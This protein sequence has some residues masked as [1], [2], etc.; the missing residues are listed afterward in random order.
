MFSSTSLLVTIALALSVAANPILFNQRRAGT[1]ITL[2]SAKR[3][4]ATGTFNLVVRDQARAKNLKAKG[5]NP[6]LA[7]KNAGVVGSIP[8]TNQAVDYTVDV[9]VGNPPTTYTLLVDTGSSNTWVGSSKPYIQTSTSIQTN[10]QVAVTYGIGDMEGTEFNDKLSLDA[11]LNVFG[12]SLGVAT[13]STGFDD[14]DGILGLGPND[15]TVGT[16]K[17]DTKSTIPTVTDNLF[18]QAV[19]AANQVAISFEPTTS[20][21][22]QNGEITFGGTDSS[23]FV[24]SI[25][26]APIT[27]TKPAANFWG[28]DQAIRFGNTQILKQTAGIVDTGTTLTLIASDAFAQYQQLTGGIPNANT[29]LLQIN[30]TQFS[31]LKSLFFTVNNV[32]YEFTADAQIWPRALNSAI[33]GQPDDI[34]LVVS[35]LGT[36]SGEGLDFINGFTFLER[37]YSVYDTANKKV[38]LANTPF[39]R[40][41]SNFNSV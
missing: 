38:G 37:F 9:Q 24:G 12:Q 7:F 29:G 6:T 25:N 31:A 33:G 14:V 23:K 2:K 36:P 28:I 21:S 19:I 32:D 35:D 34:F 3:V 30:A 20:L 41:T 16:L 4:N 27:K 10:D 39:T 40:A 8:A 15:L 17:P 13:S 22:V 18:S 1:P 26:L 5:A 11:G